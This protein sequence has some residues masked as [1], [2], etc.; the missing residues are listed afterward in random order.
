MQLRLCVLAVFSTSVL[1]AFGVA[2]AQTP[3]TGTVTISGSEQGPIYPCGNTSCPTYDSGQITIT[4]NGFNAVT[5]YSHTGGQ[6]TSQQLANSLGTK[7][8]TTT[9]PVTAVVAN[10]KIT[11]T[12]KLPGTLSNYPLSTFVTHSS[13]FT[14]ASFAAAP[15]P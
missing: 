7:L 8:N 4:V 12:S 6:K 5:N 1:V 2:R 9:S 3:G 14:Q 13:L 11:L 10:A 15:H